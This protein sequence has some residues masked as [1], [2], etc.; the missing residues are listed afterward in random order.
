MKH[1]TFDQIV[2]YQHNNK[3]KKNE[4][5]NIKIM[6]NIN[7]EKENKEFIEF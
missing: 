4:V 2:N 7:K 5:E 3:K 1:M 6:M